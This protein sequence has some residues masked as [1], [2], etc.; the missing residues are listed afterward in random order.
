[1]PAAGAN[2]MIDGLTDAEE[3][4]RR[5]AEDT[6]SG[7]SA[8]IDEDIPVFDRADALPKV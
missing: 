2:E 1:M 6:P 4:L 8:H 3:V 7:E 5:A